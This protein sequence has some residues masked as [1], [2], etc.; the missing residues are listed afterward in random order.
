MKIVFWTP[1]YEGSRY[2][3]ENNLSAQDVSRY[4]PFWL[5]CS[6][7]IDKFA[8]KKFRKNAHIIDCGSNRMT[9]KAKMIFE[10]LK[11]AGVAFDLLVK[12]DL[13]STLFSYTKLEQLCK[14]AADSC[15]LIGN[16]AT[17]RGRSYIRGGMQALTSS[18]LKQV[19]F[20]HVEK[21]TEFLDRFIAR[22]VGEER[23]CNQSLFEYSFA[24]RGELPAYH[25]HKKRNKIPQFEKA[26]ELY[27][28]EYREQML[29][30][31]KEA[32]W[33]FE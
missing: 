27:R 4:L 21:K 33:N 25:P 9:L 17:K 2:L 24:Y 5:V 29:K 19:D 28:K 18:L 3:I 7:G 6:G 10:L 8:R 22:A 23:F 1:I 13:D 14:S 31:L 11:G 30:D 20:P 32:S 15:S 12:F 16:L 26:I